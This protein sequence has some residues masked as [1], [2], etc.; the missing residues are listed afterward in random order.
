MAKLLLGDVSGDFLK[1][2]CLEDS[3]VVVVVF[4][5]IY[6]EEGK[7]VGKWLS[8][9]TVPT[10]GS[11]CSMLPADSPW[12]GAPEGR[13]VHR[14]ILQSV[15]LTGM[16][17]QGGCCP[18]IRQVSVVVWCSGGNP[19]YWKPFQS[20]LPTARQPHIPLP[21]HLSHSSTNMCLTPHF[22]VPPKCCG[23]AVSSSPSCPIRQFSV[24]GPY[25]ITRHLGYTLRTDLSLFN[26]ELSL[27]TICA[28]AHQGRHIT[29]PR[30]RLFS[31]KNT[32][33]NM[34]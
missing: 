2:D 23:S 5:G 19:S 4:E 16:P 8:G 13:Y 20:L 32:K 15:Y 30:P 10:V 27:Y 11:P 9:G 28:L 1:G 17:P 21:A 22:W 6:W 7:S 33:Q 3:R 29:T 12:L 25:V 24:L 18:L 31:S 26:Q 14:S 34:N